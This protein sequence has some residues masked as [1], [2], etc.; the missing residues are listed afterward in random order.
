MDFQ[1]RTG[2]EDGYEALL[3]PQSPFA[4]H[5]DPAHRKRAHTAFITFARCISSTLDPDQW[6]PK[7]RR[8]YRARIQAQQAI[9]EHEE[10]RRQQLAAGGKKYPKMP[11][12]G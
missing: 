1:T 10:Q 12:P 4:T 2:K 9:A 8:R 7:E 11:L 6:L 3:L 5:Q